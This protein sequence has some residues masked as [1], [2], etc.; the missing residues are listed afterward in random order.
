MMRSV[1]R[2]VSLSVG[3]AVMVCF[4]ACPRDSRSKGA[5]GPTSMSAAWPKRLVVAGGDRQG[6]NWSLIAY[7]DHKDRHCLDVRIGRGSGGGC[8]FTVSEAGPISSGVSRLKLDS[9]EVV[10][11]VS[12][13]ATPVIAAVR[14]HL[15]GG[16]TTDLRTTG[17]AGLPVRV[18]GA[19]VDGSPVRVTGLDM[20]GKELGSQRS[21]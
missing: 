1:N 14:V 20:N 5:G 16:G 12:G 3:L 15:A 6:E 2:L 10:T 7:R 17:A 4:T 19:P 13:V 18:F 9:G 11:F 21:P 8:G